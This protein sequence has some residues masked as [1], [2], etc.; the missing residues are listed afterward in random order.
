MNVF[1]EKKFG[2]D[3]M[4]NLV[5][6][7]LLEYINTSPSIIFEYNEHLD[8][9]YN[10]NDAIAGEMINNLF[11]KNFTYPKGYKNSLQKNG[12]FTIVQLNFDYENHIL[13]LD[14]FEHYIDNNH[15]K[16][17]IPYFERKIKN[18]INSPIFVLSENS[19]RYDGV[20]TSFK[21]YYK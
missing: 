9:I 13:S 10:N 3:F 20:K 2:E 14:S 16:Q 4:I 12:S 18:F 17:F 21:I 1:T 6:Q 8:W 7:S 15:N 5:R 19:G 11:F